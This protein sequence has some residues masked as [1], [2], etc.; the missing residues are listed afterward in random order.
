VRVPAPSAASFKPFAR[1]S[2]AQL[3]TLQVKL[4]YVGTQLKPLPSIGFSSKSGTFQLGQFA[5]SHLVYPNDQLGAISSCRPT[6][7]QL[8]SFLQRLSKVTALTSGKSDA[9]SLL[10]FAL[11]NKAGGTKEFDEFLGTAR[12]RRLYAQ[13]RSMGCAGAANSQAPLIGA[14]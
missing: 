4:T 8:H 12:V 7:T 10:N 6:T 11:V 9:G 13:L 5:A 3:K 2:A 14:T 1:M